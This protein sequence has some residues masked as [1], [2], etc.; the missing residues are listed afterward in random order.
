MPP[1]PSWGRICRVSA[2]ERLRLGVAVE[3]R[4]LGDLLCRMLDAVAECETVQPDTEDGAFDL[5]LTSASSD[6]A[7]DVW[8]P[9]REGFA[10]TG[11]V[12]LI[13]D[14]RDPTELVARIRALAEGGLPR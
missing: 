8:M 3:P 12:P 5:V 6:G 4:L 13:V 2:P 10:V 1:C 9:P 7:V 11:T 14:L